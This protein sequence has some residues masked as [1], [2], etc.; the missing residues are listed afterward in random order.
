MKR[1]LISLITAIA[2]IAAPS[3]AAARPYARHHHVQHYRGHRHY[4]AYG[5]RYVAEPRSE[6]NQGSGF[7]S[8]PSQQWQGVWRNHD[9]LGIDMRGGV[10]GGRPRGCPHAFCGCGTS[11]FFFGHIVGALNVAANWLHFPHVAPQA[12]VAAVAP[13]RHHVLAVV[14]HVSGSLYEVHDSNS[15]GG[16]TRNHV[17]NLSGYTFVNPR[18]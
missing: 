7:L 5:H 11:L 3:M 1:L 16:L 4:R 13:S 14:S 6:T 10:V 2:L 17:R 12:G 15:G 18:A 9:R 8:A